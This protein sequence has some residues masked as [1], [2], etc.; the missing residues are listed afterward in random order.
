MTKPL[1]TIIAN[2]GNIN[3]IIAIDGNITIIANDRSNADANG[4][5]DDTSA[6]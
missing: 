3:I 6:S 5:V 4:N 2:D 1:P